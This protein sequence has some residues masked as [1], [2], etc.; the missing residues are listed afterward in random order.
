MCHGLFDW[1]R[2]SGTF[3]NVF[4]ALISRC[5]AK[6]FQDLFQVGVRIIRTSVRVTPVIMVTVTVMIM[7]EVKAKFRARVGNERVGL[8]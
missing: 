8:E 3:S 5:S 4:A 7:V 2:I 1:V 6:S